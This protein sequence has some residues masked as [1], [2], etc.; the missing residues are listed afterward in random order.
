M[1]TLR[2]FPK[3]KSYVEVA[4][5]VSSGYI[6]ITPKIEFGSYLLLYGTN[7]VERHR[8]R[9]GFRTTEYMS[10]YYK[11]RLYGAYG[12]ND[13]RF[14]Y[15]GSAEVFVSR[16]N[17]IKLGYQY[18]HDLQG[19]GIPDLFEE[20]PLLEAAS[21]LGLLERMNFV[22]QHRGWFQMDLHRTLTQKIAFS[23]KVM[24]PEGEFVFAWQDPKT[25]ELKVNMRVSEISYQLEWTPKE[26]RLINGNSRL[27]INVNKAPDFTLTYRYGFDGLL[28]SDFEYH[29]LSLDMRQIARLGIWGRAEYVIKLNKTF[30]PL[31]YLMLDIFPGNETFVRTLETYVLMD[32][33]EKAYLAIGRQHFNDLVIDYLPNYPSDNASLFHIGGQLAEYTKTHSLGQTQ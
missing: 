19:I 28:G 17:W 2:N 27:N 29:K 4:K 21:Q 33:F 20:D 32:F 31:P 1:D 24:R 22:D 15:G 3:L 11:L 25:Q 16:K 10:P 6:N 26:T 7:V 13:Q 23:S 30:T 14:K 12:L 5:M 9:I 8:F 18:K